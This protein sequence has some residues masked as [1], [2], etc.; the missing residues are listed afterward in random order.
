MQNETGA[1][2]E[3]PDPDVHEMPSGCCKEGCGKT[4]DLLRCA[5]C[6]AFHYCGRDHQIEDRPM[7]KSHCSSIKRARAKVEKEREAL[8]NH[9]DFTNDNPFE[10]HVG[11]FWR[12][13]ETRPYM[14]ALS[15]L[16][17]SFQGIKHLDAV[18]AEL[19]LCME[20]LRLSPGDN[21]GVRG[22]VPP[23][24]L[25]LNKDQ[26][27]YDFLKWHATT[28]I[29]KD[30][31]Y[32]DTSRFLDIKNADIFEPV[33][34]LGGNAYLGVL[35]LLISLA[36]LKIKLALDLMK[37]KSMHD[38]INRMAS[39]MGAEPDQR[40]PLDAF[41]E[42]IE[43]NVRSSA[44]LAR[45]EIFDGQ[46]LAPLKITLKKQI[47]VIFAT[48]NQ[49]NKHF[50]PMVERPGKDLFAD[51]VRMYGIGSPEEARA[52]LHSTWD[53]WNEVKGTLEY[54]TLYQAGE[55]DEYFQPS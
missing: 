11:R 29:E 25:R 35:S 10:N 24:L 7:H 16:T 51:P 43:S 6:K 52:A 46:D 41:R 9:S 54:V 20:M 44:I 47:D 17:Q 23:L 38:E 53:A 22:S 30:R 19:D 2:A 1:R 31:D 33:D 37:I 27:C 40:P 49:R 5:G 39:S 8:I 36:I 18:Q 32:S 3:S 55:L 50:L 15:S 14:M 42:V 34:F 26:E 21:M 28:G 4:E 48:L 12:I 13:V 45:P